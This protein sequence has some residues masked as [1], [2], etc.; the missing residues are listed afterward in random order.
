M[1]KIKLIRMLFQVRK[2]KSM[3]L[4]ALKTLEN[5]EFLSQVLINDN[6]FTEQLKNVMPETRY[7]INKLLQNIDKK[8]VIKSSVSFCAG[9]EKKK[10]KLEMVDLFKNRLSTTV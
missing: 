4:N 8:Y 5:D 6:I 7:Y 3:Y 10:T 9:I 2:D 1:A